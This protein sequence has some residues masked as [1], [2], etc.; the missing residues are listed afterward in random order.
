MLCPPTFISTEY[1]TSFLNILYFLIL[2]ISIFGLM[3]NG[4]VIWFLGFCMK[5][6]PFTTFILNLG[7]PFTTF[8]LHLAR[9]RSRES[10]KVI[11]QRLFKEE[12]NCR[13]E[14]ELRKLHFLSLGVFLGTCF[15]LYSLFYYF[16]FI[17]SVN[18]CPCFSSIVK[19]PLD[20]PF[21]RINVLYVLENEIKIN[22][23]LTV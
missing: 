2:V 17:Y 5:R 19:S 3:G 9:A 1:S 11:L 8:I 14:R 20:C 6:N 4:T 18:F 13:E 12:E 21:G 15:P 7:N 16:G 22:A 10:M 23:A